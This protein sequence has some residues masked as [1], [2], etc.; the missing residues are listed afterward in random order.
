MDNREQLLDKLRR[1]A[2]QVSPSAVMY[3]D[4]PPPAQN[5]GGPT[6]ASPPNQSALAQGGSAQAAPTQGAT[7][8]DAP[9]A[10]PD[11]YPQAQA[12]TVIREVCHAV[13][14]YRDNQREGLVQ[15]RNRVA[16]TTALTGFTVYMLL[17]LA[18]IWQAPPK[19][20]VA[21]AAFYIVG[22]LIGLFNRLRI[23]ARDTATIDDFWLPLAQLNLTQLLSGLAAV[24]GVLITAYGVVY[25]SA[26]A[27][28]T[29]QRIPTPNEIYDLRMYPFGLIVA[30]V[31][32]L[33]PGL[34]L[35]GLQQQVN[36]Y[37]D[38]LTSTEVPT[39]K[40]P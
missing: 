1:A 12:R 6:P 31:F 14:E 27:T 21:A 29:A 7:A 22:A 10:A 25:S 15:A 13:N 26:A 37:K 20:I 4:K 33:S 24:G 39:R 19:A 36:K 34:L 9:R 5:D 28:Q 38:A 40:G 3:L 16:A 32:G 35:S 30:A 8:Q 23:Q 18:I 2:Q 17:G 11:C